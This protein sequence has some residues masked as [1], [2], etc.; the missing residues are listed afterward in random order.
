MKK[1]FLKI[2]VTFI[3]L[4]FLCVHFSSIEVLALHPN[5][6][7]FNKYG[8]F[9][10]ETC[11]IA[12]SIDKISNGEKFIKLNNVGGNSEYDLLFFDSSEINGILSNLTYNKNIDQIIAMKAQELE[13][14]KAELET[15]R[16]QANEAISQINSGITTAQ[17]TLSQLENQKQQL[18]CP[19]INF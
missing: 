13:N 8:Q 3:L 18:V 4:T 15:Q 10:D 14:G 12:D 19:R 11:A 17:N 2:L 16:T 7:K 1:N 5:C 6:D 9:E